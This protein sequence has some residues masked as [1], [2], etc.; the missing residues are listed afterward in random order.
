MSSVSMDSSI[1]VVTASRLSGDDSLKSP[2]VSSLNMIKNIR[3][4][5]EYHGGH[6]IKFYPI[7]GNSQGLPYIYNRF[8][9]EVERNSIL[10][11]VHDDVYIHDF[12]LIQNLIMALNEFDVIGI[13][14]NTDPDPNALA[15][16]VNEQRHRDSDHLSGAVRTDGII[17]FFGPSP[18]RVHRLDGVFIA[19]KARSLL[20]AG[21]RFDE[22]FDFHYYDLDFSRTASESGLKLGT[23][24]IA[25]TH[26]SHGAF[27]GDSFLKNQAL[28]CKKW[29]FSPTP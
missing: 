7:T 28:F 16:F 5:D 15:W 20:D 23:W 22:R 2:I 11:F 29:G 4:F 17:T 9:T 3:N 1:V 26:A 18:A 25:I 24:P 6:K 21:V 10:I 14:G 13:A 27:Y 19:A 8:I 12:L